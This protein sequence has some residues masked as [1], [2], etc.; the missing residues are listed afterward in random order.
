MKVYISGPMTGLPE[1]NYPAFHDAARRWRIKYPDWE[2]VNP[3]EHFDGITTLS[4]AT[5]LR[6]DFAEVLESDALALLPGWEESAG[7]TLEVAIADALG[8]P[9]FHALTYNEIAAP[10]PETIL[11]EAQRLVYGDRQ[12]SYGHPIDDF[13]RTAAMWTGM[14]GDRLTSALK[15][16]DVALMMVLVKVSR[17]CHRPKR[18]NVTDIAGYAATLAMVRERQAE[19]T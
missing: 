8:L 9:K 18:D 14:L 2:I 3:A 6:K 13:S 4:R 17:E 12:E 15:P 19:A 7:A 10:K 11:Q 16:E 5:Y 1:F